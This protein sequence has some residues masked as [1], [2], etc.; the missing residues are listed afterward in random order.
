LVGYRSVVE[1]RQYKL[2]AADLVANVLTAYDLPD[3][4]ATLVPRPLLIVEPRNGAGAPL[5]TPAFHVALNSYKASKAAASFSYV[6]R[7]ESAA[8]EVIA[9]WFEA[10][11]R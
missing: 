10:I 7:L 1:S 2:D 9:R 4:A 11:E 5:D 3:L 6:E 8:D